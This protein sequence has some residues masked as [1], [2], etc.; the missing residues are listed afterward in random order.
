MTRKSSLPEVVR[1]Q[2]IESDWQNEVARTVTELIL[3]ACL[4]ACLLVCLPLF[5]LLFYFGKGAGRG[6]G[7]E[8]L[9]D[10]HLR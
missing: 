2:R 10:K 9:G 3:F 7:V 6:W 1:R 8:N 5:S 4:F